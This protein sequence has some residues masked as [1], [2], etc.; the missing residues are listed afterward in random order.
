MKLL[1]NIRKISTLTAAATSV[2]ISAATATELTV[3]TSVEAD[4]FKKYVSAFVL[5]SF[6]KFC[7]QN[8]GLPPQEQRR[9]DYEQKLLRGKERREMNR[10]QRITARQQRLEA[11]DDSD[12]ESM[13]ELKEAAL[14]QRKSAYPEDFITKG[15]RQA[16]LGESLWN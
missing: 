3:Y 6:C 9:L 4:S 10:M 2:M 12:D 5:L 7:I 15:H 1:K 8:I 14:K 13:I 11:M 16:N